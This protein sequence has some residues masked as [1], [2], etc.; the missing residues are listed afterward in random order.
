MTER[1]DQVLHAGRVAVI[2]GA[3][4]GIGTAAAQH[5][6]SLGMRLSLCDL[7][8]DALRSLASTLAVDSHLLVGDIAD[9]ATVAELRNQTITR[10][11]DVAILMNN[12]GT[13]KRAGPW[14]ST[15]DWR[16]QFEVNFW[17]MVSMQ[18]AFVPHM[19]GSDLPAA[20]VNVGSKEG[21]TTPPG[22]ASYSVAKA[23]V[24]VL[25][26]QLAHELRS[27]SGGRVSAHLLVPG[28]TW[29]PMNFPGMNET[30]DTKPGATWSA[31]QVIQELVEHLRREAFYVICPDN[32]VTR[33]L[34]A[35][36]LQWA[37]DDMIKGRPALSRWH[38]EFRDVFAASVKP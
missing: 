29:T 38:P 13:T 35:K 26:E 16:R 14:D 17:S 33:E 12:A 22:N 28:Y 11:G 25:T 37:A 27:V 24:K 7:N 20:I 21:I 36:R 3:A 32:E 9:E 8:G 4:S 23:A 15:A 34:D 2:S 30:S 31:A 10:F 18:H 1:M 5:F 19:L 6:A